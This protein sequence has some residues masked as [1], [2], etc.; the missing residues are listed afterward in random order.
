[1]LLSDQ[2]C[3][4]AR[5]HIQMDIRL[6]HCSGASLAFMAAML[7]VAQQALNAARGGCPTSSISTLE[8]YCSV[9]LLLKLLSSDCNC[10]LVTFG[11]PVG[12]TTNFWGTALLIGHEQLSCIQFVSTSNLEPWGLQAS[13]V[14]LDLENWMHKACC[15]D[16]VA[17]PNL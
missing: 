17:A 7:A 4:T 5:T 9:W 8:G 3:L 2:A 15:A 1:M 16:I 13:V 6:T 12:L 14:N 10:R 11:G